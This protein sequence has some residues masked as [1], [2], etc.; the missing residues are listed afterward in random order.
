MVDKELLAGVDLPVGNIQNHPLLA[1]HP[2][3]D[4]DVWVAVMV[5]GKYEIDK[6]LGCHFCNLADD[7]NVLTM[8]QR[9]PRGIK[10][11]Q[12]LADDEPRPLGIDCFANTPLL[13]IPDTLMSHIL[14]P[15]TLK[16]FWKYPTHAW[17]LR[18]LHPLP[19]YGICN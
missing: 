11:T 17:S 9:R 6:F 18:V 15:A 10:P 1:V 8:G 12:V 5:H 14:L 2:S 7:E 13:I 3:P 4:C 16:E 19:H